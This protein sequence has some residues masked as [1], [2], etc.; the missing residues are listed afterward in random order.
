M[1][2]TGNFSLSELTRLDRALYASRDDY[3]FYRAPGD[4]KRCYAI[5]SCCRKPVLAGSVKALAKRLKRR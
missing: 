1:K 4:R 5:G 3:S 2:Y